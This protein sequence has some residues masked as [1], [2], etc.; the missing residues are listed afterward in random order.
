[1]LYIQKYM[2]YIYQLVKIA[3]QILEVPNETII[4]RG[5]YTGLIPK[6]IMV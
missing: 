2:Y 4:K 5:K 1:M 6:Y 3:N